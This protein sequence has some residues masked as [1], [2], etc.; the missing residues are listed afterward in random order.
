MTTLLFDR[1][2]DDA[3]IFP[4]GNAGMDHAVRAHAAAVGSP[5]GRHVGP[6][7]CSASRLTGLGDALST[8]G[9]DS[10]DLALVTP[11]GSASAAIGAAHDDPRLRLRAVEVSG[12]QP[13]DPLP[14]VPEGTLLHVERPVRPPF[15]L[16]PD[17]ALKL[18]TGG[19]TPD[20]FPD[21]SRLAAALAQ[22]LR[23]K[24]TAG[25]HGAVRH[26]DP[27][28]GFEHHGF[29]NVVLAV[30]AAMTGSD[31]LVARLAERDASVVAAAVAGLDEHARGMVRSRFLSFGTCSITDPIDDLRKLGLLEE[32]S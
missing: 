20:A 22:G 5:L 18:R 29:L 24:L 26:T 12:T 10:L 19:E 7:V 32:V 9:I 21:E 16:P 27:E 31:D 30:H 6:F 15:D 2:F 14:S 11:V 28:T 25:L 3:A 1:F 13:G 17:A 8:A 23:F 4:P